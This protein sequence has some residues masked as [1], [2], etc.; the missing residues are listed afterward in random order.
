[1]EN[2]LD[3]NLILKFLVNSWPIQKTSKFFIIDKL[4]LNFLDYCDSSIFN[5]NKD[6]QMTT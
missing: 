4:H 1:M 3:L 6:R 2:Q 5:I